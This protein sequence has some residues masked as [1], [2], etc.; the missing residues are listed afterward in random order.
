MSRARTLFAILYL[1]LVVVCEGAPNIVLILADDLGYG[2]VSCYNAE[3]K[4]QTPHIDQLAREGLRFDD[5]HSASGT[6]TPSRYGLL[7]G[8]NPVR[9]GVKNTLLRRGKPIIDEKETTIAQLLRDQGYYTAMVGK[10]HLGFEMDMSGKRRQFDFS[11]PLSGGPADRGFDEFFGIHSSPSS[12]P[13][14]LIR[15]R[16]AVAEPTGMSVSPPGKR[17]VTWGRGPIAPGY[18]HRD[19]APRMCREAVRI[20][21]E[22]A[23]AKHGKPLFLYYALTSPHCPWLPSEKFVG[24][25]GC[26][27]YGDFIL[28]LDDEVGQVHKALKE[29]GLDKT[30]LLIFTSDNGPG[31]RAMAEAVEFKHQPAAHLRGSKALPYEG[32]HRVP[33]I[34]KWPGRIESGSATATTINFTDLFATFADLLGVDHL[35]AYPDVTRDTHSFL[36]ALSDPDN[37]QP[38]PPMVNT[39]DCIRVG[40]WKL[41]GKRRNRGPAETEASRFDLFNLAEDVSERTDLAPTNPERA[42]ALFDSYRNFIAKRRLK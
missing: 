8:I 14:F 16:Q 7:T 6:C 32:G 26:G 29:T 31:P 27:T 24:K 38:R 15:N 33:F 25:S 30:T 39:P 19:V 22:H 3:S 4:I 21:R 28:Q 41:V 9:T 10:W 12:A 1:A 11:K 18:E 17:S 37:R 20:I 34:A 13:Y 5:A 2:D 40:D 36:A 23:S 35:K 42:K